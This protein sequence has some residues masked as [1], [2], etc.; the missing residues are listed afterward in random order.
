LTGGEEKANLVLP[1]SGLSARP[2]PPP[3]PGVVRGHAVEPPARSLSSGNPR[4]DRLL[5]GGFPCGRLSEISGPVSSGR[6]SL[7][8]GLLAEVSSGGRFAA[9]I[10]GTDRFD[11]GQA[12]AAGIELPAILWVR[13]PDPVQ[14]LRATEILL[15]TRGF[16]LVALD[17][18]DVS[19]LTQALRAA[20]PWA[21]LAQ[22]AAGSGAAL[23]VLSERRLAGG[24]AHLGLSLAPAR[25][26]WL[27]RLLGGLD[28]EVTVVRTKRGLAGATARLRFGTAAGAFPARG[29]ERT[30]GRRKDVGKL[31]SGEL[32]PPLPGQGG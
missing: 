26:L 29:A 30:N 1:M 19:P 18:A 7:L 3:V 13:P 24:F 5:G 4:L 23:V 25:P 15:G 32:S 8:Y 9:L 28:T 16:A 2:F 20:A 14:A 21:R 31:A 6:T 10:D 17:L 27:S 11:P 12:A 22:R